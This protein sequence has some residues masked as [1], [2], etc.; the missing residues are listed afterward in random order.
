MSFSTKNLPK[1]AGLAWLFALPLLLASL[2]VMACD[3]HGKKKTF[4]GTEIY[5]KSPV[6]ESEVDKLGAYLIANELA[7][8]EKKAVQLR[9]TGNTYE[10]RMVVKK[11]VEQE[12]WVRDWAN[13]LAM[14]LSESVF[15]GNSVDVHL[16]DDSLNTLRVVVAH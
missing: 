14:H 2:L 6:T 7:D 11:S 10:F 1:K 16:C 4:H 13:M 3:D 15:E 9:K 8:G 12:G 5:Y